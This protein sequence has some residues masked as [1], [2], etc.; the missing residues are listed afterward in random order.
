MRRFSLLP[1]LRIR[2][3]RSWL[4]RG[5]FPL[6][7]ANESRNPVATVCSCPYNWFV[8][9]AGRPPARVLRGAQASALCQ[10]AVVRHERGRRY[11][12]RLDTCFDVLSTYPRTN[13]NRHPCRARSRNQSRENHQ[14]RNCR[15]LVTWKKLLKLP[16]NKSIERKR[17]H[18]EIGNQMPT[19][20]GR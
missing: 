19:V 7:R 5:T 15:S 12:L 4:P 11:A 17:T 16:E 20:G 2:P 9:A 13:P 18:G 8:S 14:Y 6:P 10:S 1:F 3:N